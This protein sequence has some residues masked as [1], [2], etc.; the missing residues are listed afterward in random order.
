MTFLRQL[1]E[2]VPHENKEEN[3]EKESCDTGNRTS[4]TG[5]GQSVSLR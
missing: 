1:V 5:E 3:K 4:N 2:D